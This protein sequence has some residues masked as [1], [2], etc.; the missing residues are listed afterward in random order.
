[1]HSLSYQKLSVFARPIKPQICFLTKCSKCN[2]T[3]LFLTKDLYIVISQVQIHTKTFDAD[4]AKF[5]PTSAPQRN[6]FS[7]IHNQ[8][9]FGPKSHF[10]THS[11]NIFMRTNA[12]TWLSYW[13]NEECQKSAKNSVK[14]RSHLLIYA[15]LSSVTT[16]CT[17]LPSTAYSAKSR[18]S[19]EALLFCSNLHPQPSP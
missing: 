16:I 19:S 8:Q 11:D 13:R 1:M 5:N 7:C 10:I 15:S 2:L 6:C 12:T 9:T 4:S 14:S 18:I 17:N 3:S